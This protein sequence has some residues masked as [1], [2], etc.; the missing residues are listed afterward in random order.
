MNKKKKSAAT[1]AG[2]NFALM[3]VTAMT[4]KGFTTVAPG[5]NCLVKWNL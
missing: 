1:A 3:S 2:H 5:D 4:D